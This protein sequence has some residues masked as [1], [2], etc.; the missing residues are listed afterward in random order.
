MV[1]SLVGGFLAKGMC[2][3][4]CKV[5]CGCVRLGLPPFRN[6]EDT[7]DLGVNCCLTH[8]SSSVLFML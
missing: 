2:S 1:G 7:A 8:F 6:S 3:L 4:G 5:M